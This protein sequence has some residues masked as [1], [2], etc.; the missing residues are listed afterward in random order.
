MKQANPDQKFYEKQKKALLK[1]K[2]RVEEKIKKLKK[3]PHYGENE[4]DNLQELEDFENN[5]SIESQL[6]FLNKKINKALRAI[7]NGSYGKCSACKENIEHGRLKIMPYADL[8]V[9]CQSEQNK[10]RKK[11]K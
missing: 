7:E 6:E 1:E 3:Y 9:T 2:E 11:H 4:E 8:C 5:L 10:G